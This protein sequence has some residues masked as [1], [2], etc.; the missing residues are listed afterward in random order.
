MNNARVIEFIQEVSKPL[1]F[2][3]SFHIPQRDNT[4]YQ[5][6]VDAMELAF[7]MSISERL[8]VDN[9]YI[10]QLPEIKERLKKNIAISAKKKE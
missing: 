7:E 1:S 8:N 10:N 6:E 2:R 4:T 5:V 9:S 3:L